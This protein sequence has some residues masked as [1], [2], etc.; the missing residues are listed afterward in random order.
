MEFV[1][2]FDIVFYTLLVERLQ[3]HVTGAIGGVAGPADWHTGDIVGV[4][5]EG[6]LGNTPIRRT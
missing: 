2:E 3:D 4:S 6:A 5:A 1:V